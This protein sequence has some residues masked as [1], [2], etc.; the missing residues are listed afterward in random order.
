LKIVKKDDLPTPEDIE[1]LKAYTDLKV[2]TQIGIVY[3]E[4]VDV[5]LRRFFE[6]DI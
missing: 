3:S 2:S 1:K 4:N 5:L 6:V